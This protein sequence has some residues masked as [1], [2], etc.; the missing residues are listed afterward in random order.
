MSAFIHQILENNSLNIAI[1]GV[2]FGIVG[3]IFSSKHFKIFYT[4]EN[5]QDLNENNRL[6]T[7]ENEI[8]SIRKEISSDL[9]QNA[10]K[11][12]DNEMS[13]YLAENFDSMV[14]KKFD[15]SNALEAEIFEDLDAKVNNRIDKYLSLKSIDEFTTYKKEDEKLERIMLGEK[16]LYQT[17][18][19]ERRS[20]GTLKSVMINL[21]IIVNFGL[22][23]LYAFKGSQLTQYVTI[24]ISGLYISLAGFIIYIFRAS[25]ARTSALLAINEDLNKQNR[26]MEY[27]DKLGSDHDLTENDVEF[28]RILMANHA[29]RE[30]NTD[31]PYEMV[32]KGISGS[33][34]QFKGGKMAIGGKKEG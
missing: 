27:I 13:N 3:I 20:S 6:N 8:K 19:Q 12:I 23:A 30:K 32:F 18:N 17:L 7:L 5:T 21:F 4:E 26:A 10:S 9:L 15:A 22:I 2:V 33:N 25:N 29:E 1:L 24:S 11:L 16:N 14:L 31:H 34:I 28:I